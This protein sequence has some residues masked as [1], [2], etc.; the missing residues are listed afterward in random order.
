M[1]GKGVSLKPERGCLVDAWEPI[2]VG[3]GISRDG[4]LCRLWST[5]DLA[6]YRCYRNPVYKTA[7]L[8]RK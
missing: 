5:E 4:D 7:W 2:F 1:L 8:D 3:L 6:N